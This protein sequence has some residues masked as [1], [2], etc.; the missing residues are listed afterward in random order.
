MILPSNKNGTNTVFKLHIEI[1]ALN[2]SKLTSV[3]VL[4]KELK[5]YVEFYE[6]SFNFKK[7]AKKCHILLNGHFNLYVIVPCC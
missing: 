5:Y 3:A 6:E 1:S 4:L 7:S 2:D